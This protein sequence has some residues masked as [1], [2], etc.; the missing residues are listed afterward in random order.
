MKKRYG[1]KEKRESLAG[2]Q[3]QSSELKLKTHTPP[4][5]PQ[6][7]HSVFRTLHIGIT[8]F[9]CGNFFFFFL[10]LTPIEADRPS[11]A[12]AV[13]KKKIDSPSGWISIYCHRQ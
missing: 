10:N 4:L 12:I 6:G 8:P 13:I 5:S 11:N 3:T 1:K 2:V 7:N 9:C